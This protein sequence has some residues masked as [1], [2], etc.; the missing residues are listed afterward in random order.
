MQSFIDVATT[1]T[2]LLYGSWQDLKDHFKK[3]GDCC[4]ANIDR[5]HNE[6]VVEFSNKDDMFRAMRK[7]DKAE[8]KN[9]SDVRTIRV[10][11]PRDSRFR[12]SSRYGRSS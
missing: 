9:H 4:Y 11:L 8:F 12:S 5:R 10:K 1:T 3:V 2:L 7:M 6:G